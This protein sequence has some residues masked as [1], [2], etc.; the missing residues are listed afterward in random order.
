MGVFA[1]G[2]FALSFGLGLSPAFGAFVGGGFSG[3][4][5]ESGLSGSGCGASVGSAGG[6]G[7]GFRAFLEGLRSLGF[8]G[9][10][11]GSVGRVLIFSVDIV[12]EMALGVVLTTFELSTSRFRIL[13][14]ISN[15]DSA[16]LGL[17]SNKGGPLPFR[18]N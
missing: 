8:E 5:G 13:A 3:F 11:G 10:S 18:Q 2:S 16:T 9:R 12:L 4:F 6:L 17:L 7:R 1:G 14:V 15:S